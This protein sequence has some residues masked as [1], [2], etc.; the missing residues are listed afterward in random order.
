[1]ISQGQNGATRLSDVCASNDVD[2]VTLAFAVQS[3]ENDG[4]T[5]YPGTNCGTQGGSAVYKVNGQ[6]SNLLSDCQAIKEDISVCQAMGTKIL[7]SI[8]GVYDQTA[9]NYAISSEQNGRDFADFMWKAFGPYDPSWTGPRPFDLSTSQHNS[10][11]GFD[12]DIEKKFGEY[13]APR[14]QEPSRPPSRA[15][16]T[17]S[18][19]ACHF[20][21]RPEALDCH[22][23]PAAPVVRWRQLPDHRR[24]AMPSVGCFLPDEGHDRRRPVRHLVD[25]VLQQCGL[26]CREWQLQ[27]R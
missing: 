16:R 4:S 5:G 19:A 9:A 25:P 24:A 22:D 23:Q 17:S 27:F 7:L 14:G 2:Y 10:V 20:H 13:R 12:F 15:R 6:D 1:M 8:G 21:S 26:R 18:L 11:D 3:P